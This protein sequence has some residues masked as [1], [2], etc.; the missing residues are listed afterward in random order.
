MSANP[1]NMR[2]SAQA[3]T[4]SVAGVACALRPLA[5][6]PESFGDTIVV[7]THL[8]KSGNTYKLRDG[9]DGPAKRCQKRDIEELCSHLNIQAGN[10]CALLTQV[11]PCGAEPTMPHLL[12][13]AH[14]LP[15]TTQRLHC[16]GALQCPC[17]L[18]WPYRAGRRLT[19]LAAV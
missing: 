16:V 6:Q 11:R 19:K 10:P 13:T 1:H 8:E 14:R 4:I 17:M 7:E 12:F 15:P 5:T 9:P 18:D 2:Y 3:S